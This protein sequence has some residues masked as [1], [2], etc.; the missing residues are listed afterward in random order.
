MVDRWL[1]SDWTQA[2]LDDVMSV[3]SKA[4]WSPLPEGF[5]DFRDTFRGKVI[6]TDCSSFD[7]TFPSWV[8]EE[9]LEIRLEQCRNLDSAYEFAVRARFEEVLGTECLIRLPNGDLF[10]QCR[11]GLMKS[12]WY[13]TIAENS[14]AQGLITALAWLRS[15]FDQD[16]PVLWAMGDD[17]VMSWPYGQPEAEKF[18]AALGT[19]GVINKHWS[20]RREFAGFEFGEKTVTPLYP[21]KHQF[22]L[23]RADPDLLRDL[24]IAFDLLYALARDEV[25][26]K[27]QPFLNR[28][29]PLMRS[30]ARAWAFGMVGSIDALGP[31]AS[32]VM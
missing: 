27:I 12:G 30:Y 23:N 26:V 13:R 25:K 31:V 5:R 4:G 16:L 10:Q 3:M 7:W 21:A 2:E 32:S 29:S 28:F 15:G 24:G 18:S 8:V 22:M 11:L 9:L 14:A 20:F 6:T 19:T 1:F 17:V